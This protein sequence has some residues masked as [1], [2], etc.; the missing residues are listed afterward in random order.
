MTK[1]AFLATKRF[2]TIKKD[3]RVAI[4]SFLVGRDKKTR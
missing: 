3:A 4:G 1:E 2:A